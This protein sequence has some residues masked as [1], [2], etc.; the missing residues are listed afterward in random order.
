MSAFSRKLNK[1]VSEL[2]GFLFDGGEFSETVMISNMYEYPNK[3]NYYM[4][5]YKNWI[6]FTDEVISRVK[7]NAPE[8]IAIIDRC[9]KCKNEAKRL[10]G[11]IKDFTKIKKY[12]ELKNKMKT[13][14]KEN[15]YR[16]LA[17]EFRKY[18][19]KDSKRLATRCENKA[20]EIAA[21]ERQEQLK[22]DRQNR[23]DEYDVLLWRKNS[24]TCWNDYKEIVKTIRTLNGPKGYMTKISAL[25]EECD[26]LAEESK[27]TAYQQLLNRMTENN[28]EEQYRL[29]SKEFMKLEDYLDADKRAI[30]CYRKADE[31]KAE[32]LKEAEYNSTL[33]Y[34]RELEND[35]YIRTYKPEAI[36]SLSYEWCK[37]YH[38][39]INFGNYKE[40]L[41]LAEKCKTYY[42][43]MN[44]LHENKI[45]WVQQGLCNYCG[46]EFG[47]LFGKKCKSCGLKQIYN[48]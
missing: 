6:M 28:S 23:K 7:A 41:S 44:K 12:E 22:T 36:H 31:I 48:N 20:N 18:D 46:G 3:K 15:D 16:N 25:S 30:D 14:S 24:A 10:Q 2:E 35:V 1:T 21:K 43:E 5:E 8:E 40:S 4:D 45:Y 13:L 26:A 32:K 37:L 11:V 29:L 42:E 34:V 19:F 9:E 17:N 39:F 38:V 27:K 47:G 33:H